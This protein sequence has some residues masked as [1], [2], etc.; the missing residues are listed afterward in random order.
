MNA[1]LYV[2]YE[3]LPEHEAQVRSAFAALLQILQSSPDL[4]ATLNANGYEE[5]SRVAPARLLKRADRVMRN[6]Q[7][8]DTWM[9]VW[10][11][12]VSLDP[13]GL[14]RRLEQAWAQTGC[15]GLALGGRHVEHFVPQADPP[16][17][18]HAV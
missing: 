3:A 14:E 18:P 8:R 10:C 11:V 7:L 4:G 5:P 15:S 1:E 9:E 16:A 2:W 17:R 12:P 13:A 6:D